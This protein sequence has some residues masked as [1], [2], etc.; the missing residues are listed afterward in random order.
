M[1]RDYTE[2]VEAWIKGFVNSM[3]DSV[4][5]G[6]AEPGDGSGVCP[7]GIKIIF[8]GYDNEETDTNDNTDQLSFAVFVH[9]TSLTKPFPP[10]ETG[11]GMGIQHRPKEEC[12]MNVWYDVASDTMEI[13]YF[14]ENDGTEL[15]HEEVVEIMFQIQARDSA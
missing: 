10:H 14:E 4:K 9:K 13:A 8:D 5:G 1:L 2:I 15:D 7:D 12:Y 3:D 6:Y 11:F